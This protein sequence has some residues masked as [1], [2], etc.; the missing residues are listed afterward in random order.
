MSRY[1]NIP[2]LKT[3]T[4][5][6]YLGSTFYPEIPYSEEDVYIYTSEGDRLDNLSYQYYGDPT[7]YWVIATANPL[8][9]FSSYF[10]PVGTQLRIPGNLNSILLN[11]QLL[12][13]L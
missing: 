11:F 9:P 1:D 6:R 12:N 7:L 8:I 3:S 10:I 2:Q 13:K 4:G 5:R